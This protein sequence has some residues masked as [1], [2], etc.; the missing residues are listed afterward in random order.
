MSK[1]CRPPT[2][3]NTRER[4]L[5]RVM[6]VDVRRIKG[7]RH[8]FWHG[9]THAAHHHHCHLNGMTKSPTQTH[10]YMCTHTHTHT[11]THTST[12]VHVQ[13]TRK[14]GRDGRERCEQSPEKAGGSKHATGK[15]TR[16]EE[17]GMG[18]A[19]I[20]K[21]AHSHRQSKSPL[22]ERRSKKPLF[23]IRQK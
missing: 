6:A 13:Y 4:Q 21:Q 3:N 17:C 15:I 18:R 10:I 7:L 5:L 23:H 16:G 19:R 9:K 1:L 11:H 22:L 8:H 14:G 12:H 20:A 2:G